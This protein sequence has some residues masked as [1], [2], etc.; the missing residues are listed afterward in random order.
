[1]KAVDTERVRGCDIPERRQVLY[2]VWRRRY[3][4]AQALPA[5][6]SK[7]NPY[8]PILSLCAPPPLSLR[9]RSSLALSLVHIFERY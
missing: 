9:S 4:Q 5:S 8:C 1:V 7:S 6:L 3:P 2:R